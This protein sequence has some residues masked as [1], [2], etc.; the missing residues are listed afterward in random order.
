MDNLDNLLNIAASTSGARPAFSLP[1]PRTD[2]FLGEIILT[3]PV[4]VR[5]YTR[6]NDLFFS[7]HVVPQSNLHGAVAYATPPPLPPPPPPPDDGIEM[8]TTNMVDL[9]LSFYIY[10]VFDILGG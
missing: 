4:A 1:P 3:Q 10:N 6:L 2:M 7:A 8:G 5:D 9:T